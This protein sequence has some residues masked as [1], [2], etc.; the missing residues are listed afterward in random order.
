V[1]V[2]ITF[3][4][5]VIVSGGKIS[6]AVAVAVVVIVLVVVTGSGVQPK[7][8]TALDKMIVNKQ[9]DSN[10]V[11]LFILFSYFTFD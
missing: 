3:V 2:S 4:V 10:H 8:T 1:V 6:V 5:S 9:E 7:I 11:V